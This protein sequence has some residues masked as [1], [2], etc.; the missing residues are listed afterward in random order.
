MGIHSH[1]QF[2]I[3]RPVERKSGK[4]RENLQEHSSESSESGQDPY[5]ALLVWRNTPSE[6]LNLSPAQRMFGRRTRTQLPTTDRLL[7]SVVG[8]RT[9]TARKIK[10]EKYYNQHSHQLPPL[11]P[12]DVIRVKLHPDSRH[13]QKG[14]CTK[15]LGNRKYEIEVDGRRYM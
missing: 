4:R 9:D 14:I 11:Q 5:M 2:S 8:A 13:H 12:G 15:H 7:E 1:D 3:S 6:G 10:Q